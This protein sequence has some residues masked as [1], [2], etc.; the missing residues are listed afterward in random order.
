MSKITDMVEEEAQRAE[1]EPDDDEGDGDGDDGH[2]PDEEPEPEPD[3]EPQ[4][5]EAQGPS[6]AQ[7]RDMERENTRHEKALA[8]IT[9]PDWQLF[10]PCPHCGGVGF[11]PLDP[12]ELAGLRSDETTTRC[13]TCDGWGQLK[14]ESRVPAEMERNC[15]QC[16][17]TGT[18][19]KLAPVTLTPPA[20][21]EPPPIPPPPT[22][23][24]ATNQW[25]VAS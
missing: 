7:L 9:G 24:P 14:T 21:T 6:D 22:W 2:E 11:S 16:G 15:S 23:N 12:D 1:S 25:E 18:I 20:T 8:K 3:E 4:E 10:N 19:V 5:P 13:P 17:G